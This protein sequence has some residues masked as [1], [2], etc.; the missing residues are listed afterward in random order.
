MARGWQRTCPVA[1]SPRVEALRGALN[2]LCR[3][4]GTA[5]R[6]DSL[7]E[8]GERS[9]DTPLGD[10]EDY[11]VDLA[12]LVAGARRRLAMLD[13]GEPHSVATLR[14][15]D[16]RVQRAIRA[17]A[18]PLDEEAAAFVEAALHDFPRPIADVL[19]ATLLYIARLPVDAP[20][21]ERPSLLVATKKVVKMPAWMPPSRTLGGFYVTD[22]IGNG[23]GGSVFAAKRAGERHTARAD[24]FALKVPDY[25]GA[26]ARTLSEAEF[27]RLFREEAGA[28]LALPDH[29]NIARFVTFDAGARPKP[30]LVMELVEGPNIER[31]LETNDLTMARAHACLLEGVATGL[32]AMHA[33]GVGHL[34][35][36]P[37]NII[38]RQGD[39]GVESPVLV[40]FGLAGRH[41][42]PGCGTAEYG[43]PEVW[44]A[45]ESDLATPV[46][47]YAFCCMAFELITNLC[48]FSADT[49]IGMI[50]AHIE[51]DGVPEG[52]QMLSRFTET[53]RFARLLQAGLR[54]QPAQRATMAQV[55]AG[56]A[57][58]REEL[59]GLPWPLVLNP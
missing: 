3:G 45:L 52:I 1:C 30:I 46:D 51:H 17:G 31:L 20:R 42:R 24:L 57:E 29:P 55:R 22:T 11:I 15:L 36:K 35:V 34:D 18:E 49:E 7:A 53:R 37:S 41:M 5:L 6:C 48:L 44:G 33:I 19:G 59:S 27:L 28:L 12:Q 40:D 47:V 23:A 10:L 21:S 58:V 13:V 39:G 4:L 16:L 26:A 54:R 32:E 25:S 2:R 9:S 14:L 50:G 38:V 43:A 8:L 56:L